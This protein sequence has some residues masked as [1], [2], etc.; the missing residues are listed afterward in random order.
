MMMIVPWRGRGKKEIG[1]VLLVHLG[2][3]PIRSHGR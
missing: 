2:T 3:H 1:G